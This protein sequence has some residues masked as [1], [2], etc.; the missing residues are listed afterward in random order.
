MPKLKVPRK[1][2]LVDMTPMVDMGFLLVTF[3]MLTTQMRPDEPVEIKKPSSIATILIPSK[4]IMTITVSDSGKVFFDIQGKYVR[5][6]LIKKM[7][8]QFHVDFTPDEINTY[9]VLGMVGVP[10]AQ[11]KQFLDLNPEQ[12]KQI[13]QPGIPVDTTGGELQYWVRNGRESDQNASVTIQG[14]AQSNYKG[15]KT[16]IS[17]LQNQ[18][19]NIFSLITNK[20]APPPGW[21]PDKPKP[22]TTE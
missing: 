17:T 18:Q 13:K 14:D 12:R 7:G 3:F 2:T 1:S 10:M 8:D 15:V 5:Q 9:A 11:M 19:V 22:N 16:V 21:E 4:D 20:E 6:S